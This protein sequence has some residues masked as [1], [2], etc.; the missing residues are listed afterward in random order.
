M[1]TPFD[2][3][4]HAKASEHIAFD[5]EQAAAF[6][7]ARAMAYQP[8]PDQWTCGRAP[9]EG[10]LGPTGLDT[11]GLTEQQQ[12]AVGA[13]DRDVRASLARSFTPVDRLS[14][15][16]DRRVGAVLG[17]RP[18]FLFEAPESEADGGDASGGT[19]DARV[20]EL[21]G[22]LAWAEQPRT[23]LHRT[24]RTAMRAMSCFG[25]AYL[26]PVVAAGAITQDDD[27][28]YRVRGE[29]GG[30]PT[31]AEALRHVFF[32]VVL[33]DRAGIYTDEATRAELSVVATAAPSAMDPADGA[34][35]SVEVSYLDAE[36]KTV[37]GRAST[38]VRRLSAGA[39]VAA[40]AVTDG[41]TY[42]LRG[43]P[44]LIELRDD[45]G[46]FIDG[47][48]RRLQKA[49]NTASTERRIVLDEDGFRIR[50]LLGAR[51]PGRWVKETKDGLE[52]LRFE[53][54]PWALSPR[55]VLNVGGEETY[56]EKPGPD[57][58]PNVTG[59]S[60]PS[61]GTF[62]AAD[63]QG[64]TD[65]VRDR[66]AELRERC[67]QA[68]VATT[69]EAGA[70]GISREVAMSDFLMDA[71]AQA[72]RVGRVAEA[73]LEMAADLAAHI[74]GQPGRYYDVRARAELRV[75]KPPIQPAERLATIKLVEA[76]LWSE[77]TAMQANGID[78]VAAEKKAVAE[79]RAEQAARETEQ[80]LALF[81]AAPQAG[82]TV[83]PGDLEP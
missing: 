26:R 11:R 79:E 61:I 29:G 65:E 70:S 49:I 80:G 16:L 47:P 81:G 38:V 22:V 64:Y 21:A 41:V 56:A 44:F 68:W 23:D 8:E 39:E 54:E 32:E 76:G 27:G 31:L 42:P 37:E 59:V 55:T 34:A 69:G 67:K 52:S 2:Q 6:D 75:S 73:V 9:G 18:R 28:A 14:E 74:A 60:R 35:T 3:I 12:R 30:T 20:A 50:V 82:E 62:E 36:R 57:G 7:E 48:A 40:S 1:P 4:R 13:L 63:P 17:H 19:E 83:E 24:L 25:V 46:A 10:F 78:D 33:P 15:V 51:P 5:A 58:F 66:T 43:R 53:P 77:G 72:A 45:A 71:E